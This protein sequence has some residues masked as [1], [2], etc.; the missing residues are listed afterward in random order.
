MRERTQ[1]L[2]ELDSPSRDIIELGVDNQSAI[3]VAYNP[4]HH[5]RVKHI[6]RRHLFVRELVENMQLR[7]PFVRTHDNLA[8]FFTKPLPSKTFFCLRDQIMNVPRPDE[9]GSVHGG[10]LEPVTSG[11]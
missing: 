11:S 5:A 6:E 4:E 1:V 8:D 3:A 2:E 7:V 10:V 9:T